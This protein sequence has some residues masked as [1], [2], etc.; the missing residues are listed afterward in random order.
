[1]Q[2]TLESLL[3][4][5]PEAYGSLMAQLF[6]INWAG[7]SFG[8]DC[9]MAVILKLENNPTLYPCYQGLPAGVPWA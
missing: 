8:A 9:L 1:M 3:W 6:L 2:R 5:T 4:L 7:L